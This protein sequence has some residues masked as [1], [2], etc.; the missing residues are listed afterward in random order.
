VTE[1]WPAHWEADVT[2]A[3][4]G[5]VRVRPITPDDADR[6]VAFH[7]RQSPESIYFRFFS[8]RPSLSAADVRRFTHVDHHDRVAF[9]ALLDDDMVGVGRYDRYRATDEAEVAFFIDDAHHGRGL[10]TILL[11]YLASAARDNGIG[12]FVATVLPSNRAMLAVFHQAGFET[13]SRFADGVIEVRF[14]LAPTPASSAAVEE[15]ASR[16]DARTV[17]RLLEPQTVAVI[18]AGRRRGTI[19]HEVLRQLLRHEFAGPVYPVN[20]EAAHVASVRAWPSI[21]DVPDQVDLA[22]VA[23]PAAEVLDAV[24]ECAR[25]RVGA[26]VVVSL[27]FDRER[28]AVLIALAH[29]H[30]IRVLGPGSFGA[31]NTDPA[32]RLHATFAPVEPR[33]GRVA[34]SLQSGTLAAGIIRRATAQ[35]LGFSSIVAV[36]DKLDVSGNDLLAWWEHDERTDVIALSLESYG[37]PR[38]FRRIAP[39]VARRKPIVAMVRGVGL[40]DDALL[41]QTGVI[42]V[43]SLD[44][45]LDAAR[46]LAWQPVPAGPRV[47]VVADSSGSLDFAVTA[48]EVAGL[49]VVRSV[50]VPADAPPEDYEAAVTAAL[51]GDDVDAALVLYAAGLDPRPEEVGA[52][53]AR[54][55]ASVPGKAVVASFP[56]HDLGGALPGSRI[57]ELGFPEAAAEALAAAVR[58]GAWCARPVGEPA[59]FDDGT[60]DIDAAL[61]VVGGAGEGRL[62]NDDAVAVLGA[63]GVSVVRQEVVASAA[64]AGAAAVAIGGPVALKAVGRAPWAKTELAGVALDLQ[65]PDE[66]SASWAR[67]ASALGAMTGGVVQAMVRPGVDLQVGLEVAPVVGL[68]LGVGTGGAA[69]EGLAHLTRAVLPLTDATAGELLERAGLAGRLESAEDR[70]AVVD[71]LLRLSVL[72]EEVPRVH[73]LLLNPVIVS[74]GS[75]WV[76]DVELEVSGEA[77]DRADDLRHV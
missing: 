30:G 39:R 16:A 44:A 50:S 27:G 21:L 62:G 56:G 72:A 26:L 33:A 43:R 73:R 11:E 2:T 58:H 53:V 15:R 51:G 57:P 40:A 31:I 45:L 68:A 5:T 46:V 4:G 75:A 3:D 71:L 37:N 19:G 74:G 13:A 54:G 12:A 77:Y 10:A 36:G 28:S 29:R 32:V 22:I 49:V 20:R 14:E 48:C 70:A 59:S 66:V 69:P 42:G 65:G 23:V 35:G 76:T 64:S 1:V 8:A 25:A 9:I 52:A 61:A 18:G 38:R 63:F 17:A 7:T 41:A 6:L 60:V 34:L 67:M 24:E 47:G 55:A